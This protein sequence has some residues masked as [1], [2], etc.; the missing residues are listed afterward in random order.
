MIKTTAFI[1]LGLCVLLLS[2]C[3]PKIDGSSVKA[4]ENS[5]V[6]VTTSLGSEK[7]EIFLAAVEIVVDR[8]AYTGELSKEANKR[9]AIS[10]KTADDIIKEATG[11]A[12]KELEE[13]RLRMSETE[14]SNVGKTPEEVIK[15]IGVKVSEISLTQSDNILNSMTRDR[16]ETEIEIT[17]RN[18]FDIDGLTA[19][20]SGV[21]Q[22]GTEKGWTGIICFGRQKLQGVV[23]AGK[24][25]KVHVAIL[26]SPKDY[27]PTLTEKENESQRAYLCFKD[28]EWYSL[29]LTWN[30]DDH[31]GSPTTDGLVHKVEV[32]GVFAGD[33]E[34][35]S[36]GNTKPSST[37]KSDIDHF[38]TL[39]KYKR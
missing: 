21:D 24:S 22:S 29:R 2:G 31:V 13:D 9:I 33:N 35:L 8:A 27:S 38:L 1:G 23:P 4:Y 11:I 15:N 16:F 37:L 18:T 14:K 5:L 39:I 3:S 26:E 20:I 30:L 17:N 10:N 25:R 34:Y 7:R 36:F 28:D 19:R 6:K 12:V 32:N